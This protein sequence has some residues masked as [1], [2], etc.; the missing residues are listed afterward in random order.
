MKKLFMVLVLLAA[1]ASVTSCNTVK[2][3]G[4]DIESVG[5]AMSDAVN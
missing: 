4:R 1:V 2:G 3:M 5:D